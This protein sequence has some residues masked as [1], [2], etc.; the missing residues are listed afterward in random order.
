MKILLIG[1]DGQ[2]GW[3]LQ[4][5]LASLGEVFAY[6]RSEFDLNLIE[7][8]RPYIRQLS[9]THII[10]AAAYTAVEKAEKD[11]QLAFH[12]NGFAPGVLAEAAKEIQATF[13]HYSTDYIFDGKKKEPY[14]EEDLPQPLNDYGKSKLAGEEA[15]KST[16]VKYLILRTSWIYGLRGKNFLNTILQLVNQNKDLKVVNDQFGSPTWSRLIAEATAQMLIQNRPH[17]GIYNLSCKGKTSWFGFAEAL[18]ASLKKE[19]PITPIS[20]SDYPSKV[21]RP[22]NSVLSNEKIGK[23]FGIFLPSWETGLKL[24]LN[25]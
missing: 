12:I 2:L 19:A 10:N 14:T 24:C 7:S 23:D 5:S 17:S 25:L 13:V 20:S 9:P 16:G 6:N 3:E 21:I 1:K 8:F 4:R 22:S 15:I 18:L 11:S